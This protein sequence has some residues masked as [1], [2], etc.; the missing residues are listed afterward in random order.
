MCLSTTKRLWSLDLFLILHF[1]LFTK[2][3]LDIIADKSSSC[4]LRT[5]ILV[6]RCPLDRRAQI[7]RALLWACRTGHTN[8]WWTYR[9]DTPRDPLT[10]YLRY[11]VLHPRRF[12]SP[13]SV[14]IAERTAIF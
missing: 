1:S 9:H 4:T 3:A 13:R 6:H 8:R 2:H 14:A 11:S 7:A 10:A 5:Y 12:A